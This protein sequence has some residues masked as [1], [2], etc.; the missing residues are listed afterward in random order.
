MGDGSTTGN[1]QEKDNKHM[2]NLTNH[3]TVT[4][5]IDFMQSTLELQLN[6]DTPLTY[7]VDITNKKLKFGIFSFYPVNS[8]EVLHVKNNLPKVI[9][10]DQNDF[11]LTNYNLEDNTFTSKDQVNS[12]SH[13]VR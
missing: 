8:I 12:W 1:M 5:R 11:C 6:E 4:F 9:Y 2:T 10:F 7:T 13:F 3:C